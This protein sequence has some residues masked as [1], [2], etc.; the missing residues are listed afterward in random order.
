MSW[1]ACLP[2]SH[3]R[4]LASLGCRIPSGPWGAGREGGSK[5]RFLG[6]G[7]PQ[8]LLRGRGPWGRRRDQKCEDSAPTHPLPWELGRL[9][10]EGA[11]GANWDPPIERVAFVS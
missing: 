10:G 7:S 9:L 1:G 3:T 4:R 11:L 5:P 6:A 2:T 8:A